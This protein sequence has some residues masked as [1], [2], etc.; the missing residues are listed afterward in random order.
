[1]VCLQHPGLGCSNPCLKNQIFLKQKSQGLLSLHVSGISTH[2]PPCHLLSIFLS[3]PDILSPL[4]FHFQFALSW[5]TQDES[6]LWK[7]TSRAFF[8]QP[9]D[10]CISSETC[11]KYSTSNE[12]QI[13]EVLL[14]QVQRNCSDVDIRS[15]FYVRTDLHGTIKWRKRSLKWESK[16][17]HVIK[18]WPSEEKERNGC[19]CHGIFNF[20]SATPP[21]WT[22]AT[23]TA[24]KQEALCAVCSS[25]VGK[26]DKRWKVSL[27][28]QR[29][30]QN[31]RIPAIPLSGGI[32]FSSCSDSMARQQEKGVHPAKLRRAG[33][34]MR[35]WEAALSPQGYSSRQPELAGMSE[36]N[37]PWARDPLR[38]HPR[39]SPTF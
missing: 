21:A 19:T 32:L 33:E 31:S 6:Q 20:S 37:S 30:Q 17:L 9:S 24:R 29:M 27:V 18:I 25:G 5:Q 7:T 39:T 11:S 2:H 36:Q 22:S 38:E 1:M 15:K 13:L 34:A 28:I 8:S 23:Q 35:T 3:F 26:R 4:T 10:H 16:K 12:F 14:L